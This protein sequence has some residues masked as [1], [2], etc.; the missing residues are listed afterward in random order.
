M[1]AAPLVITSDLIE[2]CLDHCAVLM[3]RRADGGAKLLP[4]YLRLER[5]LADWQ[6]REAAQERARARV[7]RLPGRMEARS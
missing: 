1:K 5:E 4:I 2:Q 7:R 3:S 6:G